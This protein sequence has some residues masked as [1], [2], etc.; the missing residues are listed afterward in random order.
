MEGIQDRGVEIVSIPAI[1]VKDLVF[2]YPLK[3]DSIKNQLTRKPALNDI[4]FEIPQSSR[5]L[6]VGMNGSGKSTLLN[7]LAG[8]VRVEN[9]DVNVLDKNVFYDT[10]LNNDIVYVKPD[11]WG[12]A[13]FSQ[14]PFS[15]TSGNL[16]V[17]LSVGEM[18]NSLQNDQKSRRDQLV[19][20]LQIDLN[21]RMN[22]L[23]GN[24]RKR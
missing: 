12:I 20:I 9:G 16:S 23:L 6:L 21:W 14:P 18:M 8:K 10:T 5:V 13:S 2:N 17:D 1:T 4:S 15:S 11:E 19:N 7:C 22:H 3:L 24:E